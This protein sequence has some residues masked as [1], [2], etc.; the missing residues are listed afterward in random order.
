M[1]AFCFEPASAWVAYIRYFFFFH[2]R[3]SY[4]LCDHGIYGIS[5]FL[6]S[7]SQGHL[8]TPL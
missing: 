7:Q 6:E 8:G 4:L 1:V 3:K 5:S 2:P